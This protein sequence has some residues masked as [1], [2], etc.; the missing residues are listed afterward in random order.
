MI[1]SFLY[2]NTPDG[3]LVY[4]ETQNKVTYIKKENIDEIKSIDR[5]DKLHIAINYRASKDQEVNLD[6]LAN[7]YIKYLSFYGSVY[8]TLKLTGID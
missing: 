3:A 4:N 8:V 1:T 6:F 2:T 7:R 5:N